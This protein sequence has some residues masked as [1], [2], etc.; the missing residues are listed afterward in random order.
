MRARRTISGMA[1]AVLVTGLLGAAAIADGDGSA[2]AI[3]SATRTGS[4]A[5]V[6]GTASFIDASVPQDVGGTV[7]NGFAA[8]QAADAL[9]IGLTGAEM[10][11]DEEGITFTWKLRDLPAQVLPE[12]IRYTWA[13]RIGNEQL[14]LQ[15]KTSNLVG[16]TTVDEPAGHVTQAGSDYFQLRG[17]CEDAYRGT[18]V[19]GCYHLAFL[20]GSFDS[21]A[22]TVTMTLPFGTYGSST[23]SPDSVLTAF[24]TATMP[25]TA[26]AQAAVSNTS[27]SNFINGWRTYY[28]GPR[29]ELGVGRANGANISYSTVATLAEDGTFSGTVGGLTAVLDTVYARACNGSV[30]S[31]G[32]ALPTAP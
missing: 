14:Q 26:S 23:V 27:T 29:V 17:D 5:A 7:T 4:S 22:N 30:C 15:A 24:E 11:T 31:V 20:D 18:P 32:S 2:I 10:A 13:F 9:G 8:P 6:T 25:I 12:G 19:S 16:T 21:A 3:S 28:A 1:A